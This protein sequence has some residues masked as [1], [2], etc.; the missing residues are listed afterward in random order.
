MNFFLL[1]H[2]S[3][4]S[5]GFVL[6]K[7]SKLFKSLAFKFNMCKGDGKSSFKKSISSI[8]LAPKLR[9]FLLSIKF[10]SFGKLTFLIGFIE[11]TKLSRIQRSIKKGKSISLSA[12]IE[13]ILFQPT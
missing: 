12:S 6:N 5:E 10:L 1:R 9:Y 3:L 4:V 11:E 7:Q 13:V 8:K 2:I